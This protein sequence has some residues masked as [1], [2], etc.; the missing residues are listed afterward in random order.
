MHRTRRG[1]VALVVLVLLAGLAGCRTNQPVR[2]AQVD[3]RL[4]CGS[5]TTV[6]ARWAF[7]AE[8]TPTGLVWLQH[9][10]SRSAAQVQDLAA[11]YARRGY[12][13]VSPSVASFGSCSINETSLHT[14]I[15]SVLAGAG[16]GSALG[17]SHD[18]ARRSAGL[19]AAAV[20]TRFVVSGH[21]AGGALATV[22]ASRLATDPSGPVRARLAGVVLLDPVENGANGM[23]TALPSLASVPL[24][25]VAAPGGI[26]N[27]QASGTARV[28]AARTGFIGVRLPSGC[29]CDAEADTTDGLCTLTCGT[30]KPANE[31]ALKRLAADWAD[32]MLRGRR[33]DEAVYPGGT[34]YEDQRRAGVIVTL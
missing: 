22:V 34:W 1:A 23:Q 5:G 18:A 30:P 27:S 2:T 32:D 3:L 9:G 26:C 6:K 12:A 20:P 21:S 7:P 28:R 33:V 14:A 10:F 16:P 15:A 29:H 11:S 8:G 13:V 17:S 24:L 25:V 31:A 4:P 19:P